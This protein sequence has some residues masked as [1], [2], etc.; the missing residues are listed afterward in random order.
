M[1]KSLLIISVCASLA[2]ATG[3]KKSF[4]ER[5]PLDSYTNDVLWN[6]AG[7][8][9]TALNGCYATWGKSNNGYFS[10]FADCAT[11]NAFDQF[12]WENWLGLSAGIATPTNTNYSKWNFTCIQTCNWFL[13]NVGRTKMDATLKARFIAEA[14]FLR[15]YEYFT[16]SQ[17][18]GATPLVLHNLSSD[19]ANLV[20][21]SPKADVVTFIL[22]ELAAI[23]PDLPVS[24]SGGDLGRVTR[25]AAIALKARIELFNAKYADCITDCQTLMKAPF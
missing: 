18:Y 24:Y 20:K 6:S 14:R 23:A 17:L 8:A 7:D 25:G 3:C 21:Q 5:N 19:S 4:L 2:A 9:Q 11:D 16:I 22:S 15:A 13:D 12:P 10:A 1:N